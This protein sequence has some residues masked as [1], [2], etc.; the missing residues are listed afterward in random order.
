MALEDDARITIEEE[1]R[2]V[3]RLIE[4]ARALDP[5]ERT[6][7]LGADVDQL[8]AAPLSSQRLQLRR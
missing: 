2:I 7:V 6:L 5:G 3:I 8:E 1:Q 4:Q